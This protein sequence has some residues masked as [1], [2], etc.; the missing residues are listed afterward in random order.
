[1]LVQPL[2][3]AVNRTQPVFKEIAEAS[4]LK[5]GIAS[6]TGVLRNRVSLATIASV[7][8]ASRALKEE[9]DKRIEILESTSKRVALQAMLERAVPWKRP[10]LRPDWDKIETLEA[11]YGKVDRPCL[12]I[13]GLRDEALPPSMAF[14]LALQLPRALI[15]PLRG[16]MHSPHIEAHERCATLIREFITTGDVRRAAIHAHDGVSDR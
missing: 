12:I 16:V 3:I 8:D 4:S 9:A 1:M 10:Q 11:A 6:R 14:K 7:P 2:D 15:V 5:I 13:V